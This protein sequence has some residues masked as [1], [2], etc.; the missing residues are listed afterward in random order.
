MTGPV[1]SLESIKHLGTNGGGFFNANAAHPFENPTPLTN[2]LHILGMMLIPAS[3]TYAFGSMLL[4]RRQGWVLYGAC[5]VMFIGFLSLVFVA[6]QNGSQLLA[7]AGADQQYS[8]TQSGGNMEGK[9]L[10]FGIVDTSCS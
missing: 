1:A 4:R 9:E 2:V 10:R 3:M 8:L 6:E 7:R 5:M